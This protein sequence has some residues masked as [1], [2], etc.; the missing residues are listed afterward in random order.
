[1]RSLSGNWVLEKLRDEM[2]RRRGGVGREGNKDFECIKEGSGLLA[3]DD[4]A[5]GKGA[6]KL[7]LHFSFTRSLLFLS[8]EMFTIYIKK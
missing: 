6:M 7:K 2:R 3:N 5:V 4:D 1:M 8:R